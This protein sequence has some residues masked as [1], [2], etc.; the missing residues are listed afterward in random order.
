[1]EGIYSIDIDL[2]SGDAFV[3]L[4]D[5]DG[6]VEVARIDRGC[7]SVIDGCILPIQGTPGAVFIEQNRF[8]VLPFSIEVLQGSVKSNSQM[9]FSIDGIN[10][11]QEFD[12]EIF[13]TGKTE[14]EG[15]F[16]SSEDEVEIDNSRTKIQIWASG[17]TG[18]RSVKFGSLPGLAHETEIIPSET[19]RLPRFTWSSLGVKIESLLFI[20]RENGQIDQYVFSPSELIGAKESE[21]VANNSISPTINPLRI[22]EIN[23]IC[24]NNESPSVFLSS[25]RGVIMVDAETLKIISFVKTPQDLKISLQE[26]KDVLWG[27]STAEGSICKIYE[28]DVESFSS[29]SSESTVLRTTSSSIS[30][31]S[32]SSLSSISS[33]YSSESTK[34]K[35]T[36]SQTELSSTSSSS[37]STIS[38]SSTS[39]QTSKSSS[40]LKL[41][42]GTH[43]TTGGSLCIIGYSAPQPSAYNSTNG[44]I[45]IT[46]N[47]V[48]GPVYTTGTL[49]KQYWTISGLTLY[50]DVS[51][52]HIIGGYPGSYTVTIWNYEPVTI[53]FNVGSGVLTFKFGTFWFVCG[54]P[55]IS[56]AWWS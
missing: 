17:D 27:V 51:R 6:N 55:S 9:D 13:F 47:L 16:E 53:N 12:R 49:S 11:A 26:P 10:S 56:Q 28:K 41:M 23:G 43:W 8:G 52:T 19:I 48:I 39:T 20:G 1:M 7:S 15:D 36:S 44:M 29:D 31:I 14:I 45:W 2:Q 25:K 34:E 46:Y 3:S 21:L 30:S 5:V 37:S 50:S 35:S 54:G 24:T 33:S 22:N 38:S 4:V 32:S 42:G 40:S 18:I